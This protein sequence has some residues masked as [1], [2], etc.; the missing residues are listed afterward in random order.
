MV[1]LDPE[2]LARMFA[3]IITMKPNFVRDGIVLL[4]ALRQLW[5]GGVPAPSSSA[6]KISPEQLQQM[7]LNLF[8]RFELLHRL[9]DNEIVVPS[10]LPPDRPPNVCRS[11]VIQIIDLI[12]LLDR[13]RS[14]GHG[15]QGTCEGT[16]SSVQDRLSSQLLLLAHL[17]SPPHQRLGGRLL[18]SERILHAP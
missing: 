11:Y 8:Q 2:W 18:L 5:G 13:L 12:V 7:L 9:N 1:I 3:T 10:L 16:P 14:M 6:A 4:S 17:C 15:L